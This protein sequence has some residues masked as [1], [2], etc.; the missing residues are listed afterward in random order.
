MERDTDTGAGSEG[1]A[2]RPHA[3]GEDD[4]RLLAGDAVGVIDELREVL[5]L[6]G[7]V[8]RL[9]GHA[10]RED[11]AEEDTACRGRNPLAIHPNRDLCLQ[12]DV[13]RVVGRDDLVAVGEEAPFPERAD[14]LTRH[15][16]AAEDDVLRRGNDGL[17]VGGREDV[18][19][20]EQKHPSLHLRLD[21]ERKMD[22][23]LVAVEVGV[24]GRA[25]EGVDLDG[26]ALNENRL[27]RL[28]AETVE[29]RCTV[30]HH[31]M[32]FDD[33]LKDVPDRSLFALNHALGA[34]DGRDE[35][36]LLQLVVDEG[37]EEFEC[38]LL[39]E[40]ALM[41]AELGADD[42]D[43]TARVVD[44]L[45]E[46]VLPEAAVLATEHVGERLERTLV[47]TGDGLAATAVVEEGIDRLLKHALLV[48]DDDL[49]G[50]QLEQPLEA[51][52]A[53]DDATVEVVEI[54]GR[55]AAAIE[56]DERTQ[57]GRQDGDDLEDH[58]LRLVDAD[59]EGLND[60]QPLGDLLALGVAVG[61]AHLGP[62]LFAKALD[63]EDADELADRLGT[64][65]GV[66]GV[67]PE[68]LAE[69][70][71]ALL[72]D[73]LAN[74]Q[75]RILG[76]NNRVRDAV[77]Y[78]L[79][80]LQR[81]VEEVADAAR[82]ALEEPDVG[83][84]GGQVDVTEPLAANLALDDLNAALLA[85]N[86]AVLHALVLAADALVVLHGPEDAGTEQTVALG[87]EGTVVDG[88]RLLHFA[89]RPLPD[90]LRRGQAD[91]NRTEM[92]GILRLLEKAENVLHGFTLE[93]R[94][95]SGLMR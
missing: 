14:A 55:E 27:E 52:V 19:G 43:R 37:L 62:E 12:V 18:V 86:S 59:A 88:L 77:E 48:A 11:L 21:G 94:T 16:V 79:E 73:D 17:A 23:H 69:R 90:A 6:E 13:L 3:V 65:L 31:G 9:E 32:L 74:L 36:L 87:L 34:L 64:H 39:G 93:M 56:R 57:I 35:A 66:E 50:A 45:A 15:P 8:D 70:M 49:R 42:D 47:G 84:R 95:Q 5:L 78:L 83:N 89:M 29:R 22:G 4:R 41:K 53:V 82:Q 24:E 81:D 26:L 75:R 92:E 7:P 44:A 30:E 63:V 46:Q 33:L 40:T 91:L 51:V 1:V 25:D 58:P 68:L 10:G 61:E 67:P 38:H 2:Q 85:D 80:V 28:D 76:V 20:R 72:R 60:L 54:A 71:V